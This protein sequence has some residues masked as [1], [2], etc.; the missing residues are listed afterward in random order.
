VTKRVC[1]VHIGP[2]KTG[3]KAIQW[4]LKEHREELLKRGYLVPETGN[5]HGG[6]HAIARNLCGQEI[7]NRKQPVADSFA[8]TIRK[9]SCEAVVISSEALDGLLRNPKYAKSFFNRLR[10][11][12]LQ[13]KLVIFAR[14]QSQSINS[15][16]AQVVKS[17]ARSESFEAFVQ[18]EICHPF[19]R[20]SPLI[21]LAEAFGAEL[22]SRPFNKETVA[23]GVLAEFLMAIG[24]HPSQFQAAEIRRNETVGPFTVGVAREVLRSVASVG[25]R[26]KWLQAERWTKTLAAYLEEKGWADARYCGLNTSLARHIE[27][28]LRS[29]NDA[30]AKSVWGRSWDEIF[31]ADVTKEFAPNDFD[32]CPPDWSTARRLRRAIRKMNDLAHEILSDP[33][34][35]VDAPWNDMAHRDGFISRE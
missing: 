5:I 35:A 19:F 31:A 26:L 14:N 13:P 11:L 27:S 18:A 17:F 4:F 33:E 20:Y 16:Y 7:P 28:E 24:I 2:H 29:D 23:R 8:P 10:E 32:M 9:T 21:E 12:N 22:I 34:L 30:F 1:Y 25:K 3:T 15:R 6:H